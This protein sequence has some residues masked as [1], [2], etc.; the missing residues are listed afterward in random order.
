MNDLMNRICLITILILNSCCIRTS[1]LIIDKTTVYNS[2]RSALILR[3]D[4]TFKLRSYDGLFHVPTFLGKSEGKYEIKEDLLYLTSSK[5][6]NSLGVYERE[7]NIKS[8]NK[9]NDSI[10]F[11]IKGFNNKKNLSLDVQFLIDSERDYR[12]ENISKDT[13]ISIKSEIDQFSYP[14]IIVNLRLPYYN[15]FS[16]HVITSEIFLE[17]DDKVYNQ[18]FIDISDVSIEED[19]GNMF[20]VNEIMKIKDDVI[21]WNGEVFKKSPRGMLKED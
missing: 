17:K 19:F 14:S 9:K 12:F 11:Y 13:I 10:Q 4:G 5:Q 2:K 20:F 6:L 16:N 3:D 15:E 21:K 8:T 7:I 18:F 1:S